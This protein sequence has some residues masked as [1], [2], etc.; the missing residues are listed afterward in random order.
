MSPLTNELQQ[1]LTELDAPSALALERLVRDA[2]VLARP[3]RPSNSLALDPNG[4]PL[5]YFQKYPGCLDGDDW[6][7]PVDLPA[8][9]A[10]AP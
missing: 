3:A 1:T 2:M 7:P 10:P 4:W 6:Q 8:E 9:A 5:G